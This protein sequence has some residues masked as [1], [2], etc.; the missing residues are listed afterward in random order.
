MERRINV[1]VSKPT[2]LPYTRCEA[3]EWVRTSLKGVCHVVMPTF[4]W[5]FKGLDEDAIR[6][7]VRLCAQ[8]GF[9]QTLLVSEGGTT[10]DEYLQ[11]IDS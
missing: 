6:H 4:T 11:F 5:D 9:S 2:T 8:L 10:F 1:A 7:D 3:K